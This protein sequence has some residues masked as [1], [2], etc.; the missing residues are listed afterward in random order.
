VSEDAVENGTP[1]WLDEGEISGFAQDSSAKSFSVAPSSQ[2]R[3]F[4]R[5]FALGTSC[6]CSYDFPL[7][8]ESVFFLAGVERVTF[9]SL[10]N[11]EKVPFAITWSRSWRRGQFGT[12]RSRNRH[13]GH[14]RLKLTKMT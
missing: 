2:A 13:P 6:C 9:S 5:V 4:K 7:C 3:I 14:H 11:T 12:L 1:N 10:F 8:I